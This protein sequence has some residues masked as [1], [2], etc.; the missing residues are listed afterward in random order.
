VIA[1][2][3]K[4]W[5]NGNFG[6]LGQGSVNN[7]SVPIAVVGLP[8]AAVAV[9]LGY[10]HSCALLADGDIWCWGRGAKGQLGDGLGEDSLVP[11]RVLAPGG[12]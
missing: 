2:A 4:C 6:R 5:G 10:A 7:S 8:G 9:A 1:G 3:V 11:V 12:A